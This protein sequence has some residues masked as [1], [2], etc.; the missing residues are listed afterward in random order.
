MPAKICTII[1]ANYT[2]KGILNGMVIYSLG[3]TIASMMLQ[4]FCLSRV[5][6]I[7]LVGG[8]VYSLEI[9][10][11][12]RW[13]DSKTKAKSSTRFSGPL[14]RTTLALAYFNP[15]W[16]ARH[17]AFIALF[18]DQFNAIRFS[19]LG[20]AGKSF[21]TN[22]PLSVLANYL[23]QNILPYKYRFV[24]SAIFSSLM[25]VYYALSAVWFR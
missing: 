1:R 9:P 10:A 7:C 21:V 20:I 16:I 19:I 18:S 25:A 11:Y 5:I 24:G 22:I 3:D 6:G 13:I 2:M 17:L 23:I 15:L 8:L 14:L 4:Q 12:F